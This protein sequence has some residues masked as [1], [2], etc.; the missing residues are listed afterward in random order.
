MLSVSQ[1]A[2]LLRAHDRRTELGFF[3]PEARVSSSFGKLSVEY[4][5]IQLWS[6]QM[7]NK[8]AVFNKC[9]KGNKDTNDSV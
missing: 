4:L 2:S 6:K 9:V 7:G 1:S 8:I 5:I 3:E